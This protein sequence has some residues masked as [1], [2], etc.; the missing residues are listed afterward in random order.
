[1]S[2]VSRN[3]SRVP[4]SRPET[5]PRR[6]SVSPKANHPDISS[7]NASRVRGAATSSTGVTSMPLSAHHLRAARTPMLTTS[8]T[9]A[10]LNVT[11]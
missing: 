1:M 2:M 4:C 7:V 3:A 11:R 6:G 10:R 9:L 8:A 5:A